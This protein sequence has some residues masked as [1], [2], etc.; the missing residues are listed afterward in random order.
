MRRPRTDPLPSRQREHGTPAQ[1]A[2]HRQ[3]GERTCRLRDSGSTTCRETARLSRRGPHVRRWFTPRAKDRVTKDREELDPAE[4]GK[5]F[6]CRH[7]GPYVACRL[8]QSERSTSTSTRSV[9]P[10]GPRAVGVNRRNEAV[11]AGDHAGKSMT[12][13]VAPGQGHQRC[14]SSR[15]RFSRD[16]SPRED[17]PQPGWL[18]HLVS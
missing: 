8:L 11:D 18:E 4:A 14:R 2:F 5:L 16:R 12:N 10:C 17:S 9:E 1:G 15:C 3:G 7:E 6:V 13:R